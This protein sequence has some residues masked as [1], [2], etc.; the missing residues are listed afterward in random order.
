MTGLVDQATGRISKVPGEGVF[1]A[2]RF[3]PIAR[4]SHKDVFMAETTSANCK[5]VMRATVSPISSFSRPNYLRPTAMTFRREFDVMPTLFSRPNLLR[6][7]AMTNL[8]PG[9][10]NGYRFSRPNLLRP[11]AIQSAGRRCRSATRFSRP[12]LLR[13]TA[14]NVPTEP[15]SAS[16][17]FHGR[18]FFGLLQS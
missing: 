16:S 10:P 14:I 4:E 6:P 9:L 11:T 15:Q 3:Q 8:N 2:E 1:A 12:N 5:T 17:R 7:T 13:P 18:I